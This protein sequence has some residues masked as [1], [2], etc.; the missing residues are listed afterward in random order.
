MTLTLLSG[1]TGGVLGTPFTVNLP[2]NQMVRLFDIFGSTAGNY[3]NGVVRVTTTGI[4]PSPQT[5]PG[6]IAYCTLQNNVQFDA[7]FR[8]AKARPVFDNQV[9]RL[10]AENI[11]EAGINFQ[12]GIFPNERSRH[13]VYFKHPD[14][15]QCDILNGAGGPPPAGLEIRLYDPEGNLRAGGPGVQSFSDVSTG[16]KGQHGQ[17]GVVMG[18][19]GKWMVDVQ[20]SSSALNGVMYAI[21]CQSGSGHGGF[22]WIGRN[23]PHT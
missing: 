8:I 1:S 10:W 6:A 16:N 15:V 21:R 5:F 7:D 19:N 2:A 23:L 12:L 13:V 18:V 17:P 3:S 11:D 4:G 14:V 9:S 20:A 22:E